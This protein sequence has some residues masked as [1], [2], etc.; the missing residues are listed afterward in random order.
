[1]PRFEFDPGQGGRIDLRA[2]LLLAPFAAALIFDWAARYMQQSVFPPAGDIGGPLAPGWLFWPGMFFGFYGLVSFLVV[3]PRTFPFVGDYLAAFVT[4]WHG[5]L[6]GAA[7]IATILGSLYGLSAFWHANGRTLVRHSDVWSAPRS[8]AWSGVRA[9]T[10]V[11]GGRGISPVR[12]V[13]GLPD[14]TRVDLGSA[15]EVALRDQF[16]AIS[17]GTVKARVAMG[18]IGTCPDFLSEFISAHRSQVQ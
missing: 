8:Y 7:L 13:V 12:L 14:G 10:L 6:T 3:R 9:A 16:P 11:C 15:G 5:L 1:M 18:R 17:S 4:G 2:S